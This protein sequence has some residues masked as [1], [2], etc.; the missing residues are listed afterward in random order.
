VA[1]VPAILAVCLLLMIKDS[2]VPK[3]ERENI[4]KAFKST[5]KEFKHYLYSAAIF[6]LAYFSFGFL[7]LKAYLVGFQVKDVILLY[8]LFNVAFVIVAPLFGNLGDKIGRKKIVILGYA[9][10]FMMS[11]GFIFASTKLQVIALFVLFGMFFAIDES[12]G[13]AY[14]TDIEKEKRGTAMGMYNFITGLIYLPA[15]IIAGFLWT[16]NPNYAFIFAGIVSM[17][18][19]AYF[20]LARHI[21]N[22]PEAQEN[23]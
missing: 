7:L 5:S 17:A 16:I 19:L 13:K 4:F 22:A 11:I 23:V 3:T 10:Y 2:P 21:L 8:A 18:A 6:S 12:Q 14:I 1:L 9:F 20:S 15:S